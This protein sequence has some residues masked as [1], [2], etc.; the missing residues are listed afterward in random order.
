M[1]VLACPAPLGTT[2][3]PR[4]SLHPQECAIR[5][6]TGN[7]ARYWLNPLGSY[8][9]TGCDPGSYCSKDMLD[10][11]TGNCCAGYYC[12]G[13]FTTDQPTGTGVTSYLSLQ[14]T[15]APQAREPLITH[16]VC[17]A[18]LENTVANQD[19]PL[20]KETAPKDQP[21]Q[22]S[23]INCPPGYFCDAG[24]Y[25][26]IS[27][28]SQYICPEALSTSGVNADP[29]RTG[30]H[31]PEQTADSVPCL[32]GT[33]NPS[34][35]LHSED[36]CLNC[37]GGSLSA[38]VSPLVSTVPWEGTAQPRNSTQSA[39][40]AQYCNPG[41][42][43]NGEGLANV[44]GECK[45][46]YYCPVGSSVETEV[47]CNIGKYCPTGTAVPQDCPAG[48]F[49]GSKGKKECQ[50]CP[51]DIST[52]K[53][54]CPSGY[55]CPNGNWQPCPAGTYS[56]VK[57]LDKG[58]RVKYI[59]RSFLADKLTSPSGP[60]SAGHY[61]TSGALS[62]NP[63]MLRASQCPAGTVHPIVGDV[64]PIGHYCPEGT[65]NPISCP[66]GTYQDLTNQDHC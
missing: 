10:A 25:G 5:A 14:V 62:A 36:Q 23:C 47:I 57:G 39:T 16:S 51:E 18:L 30:S 54:A 66:A 31:C 44:T 9:T 34:L 49:T 19:C 65:E 63:T 53:T 2:V 43:C 11:V 7:Q 46:G 21:I 48:Y 38:V 37:T 1:K 17:P 55:F 35:L 61:C 15:D 58:K 64:C 26:A 6:G 40:T 27:N 32:A 3:L 4:G 59:F 8:T 52:V 12:T 45:K 29:S 20:L 60:C 28:Y 42:Y 22:S 50:I 13:N 33:F 41:Y 24:I 56:A